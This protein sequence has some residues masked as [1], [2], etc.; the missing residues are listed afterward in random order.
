MR[1]IAVREM[2]VDLQLLNLFLHGAVSC[3][4]P[5]TQAWDASARPSLTASVDQSLILICGVCSEGTTPS[6]ATHP[7]LPTS[8]V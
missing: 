2:A 1:D 4:Y 8:H 6:V 3:A 7:S 5:E